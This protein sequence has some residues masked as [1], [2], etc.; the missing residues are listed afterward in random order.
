[1]KKLICGIIIGLALGVST[2]A[3]AAV[4]D[5]V[6]AVFAQFNYVVNGQTKTLDSP[7]LVVDGNSYLRTTQI[8]N[9]LGY[10]V[11]Y[12]AD[13]RTIEFNKPEVTPIPSAAPTPSPVSSGNTTTQTGTQTSNPA[14]T[15]EPTATV[16]PTPTPVP[17]STSTQTTTP[18][19]VPTPTPTPDNSA[20]CQAIRDEY[21]GKIA[22][23]DYSGLKPGPMSLEKHLLAYERD[24][25][26]AANGCN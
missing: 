2:N 4:G 9:M 1:M 19:P 22:M 24:Q 13:S 15:T 6:Q 3:F 14:T 17:P 12:K 7:V 8:S 26:L 18:T 25:A 16:A 5:T 10:D 21:A 23:V 20:S 11:T